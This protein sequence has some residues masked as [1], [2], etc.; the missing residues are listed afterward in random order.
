GD[1]F[2]SVLAVRIIVKPT[3]INKGDNKTLL[4]RRNVS[5]VD[6]RFQSLS[7]IVKLHSFSAVFLEIH[8][9]TGME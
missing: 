4:L 5:C 9:D 3:E 2:S 7:V 1:K 8:A 6:L